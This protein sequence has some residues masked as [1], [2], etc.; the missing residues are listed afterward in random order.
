MEAPHL[1]R[2]TEQ[3]EKEGLVVLAVN[4]RDEP[5]EE[6]AQYLKKHNLQL[7]ILLN[8]RHVKENVYG[9]MGIPMLFWINR[10]GVISINDKLV[11]VENIEAIIV[12]MLQEKPSLIVAFNAD[13]RCPYSVVSDV[14]EELKRANAVRVSFTSDPESASQPSRRR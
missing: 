9:M 12:N 13:D 6:I 14:M 1:S 3:Y 11:A 5:A 2:I 10:A 4:S 7:L 8:G